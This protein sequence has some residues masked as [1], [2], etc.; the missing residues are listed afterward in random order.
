M[1]KYK[2]IATATFGIEAIVGREVKELGIENV[3]VDNARVLYETDLLGVAKSNLWLRCADRVFLQIGEFKATSF[4]ELFNKTEALPWEKFIPVNGEFPVNGKSV[5]SKLFSVSD[6]Q[7]IVKKAIV[8]R[9]GKSYGVDWFQEDGPK[10]PILVS[11]LKDVVTLSIDT[12]GVGLHKRG[13][14]ATG[15]EA[16]LKETLAAAMLKIARWHSKIPLIDPMCGSGTILIEAAMMGRNIAPGLSRKFVSETWGDDFKEAF[17]AARKEAYDAIE[18]DL[19]LNIKGYD[20]NRRS[21]NIAK[22]NAELAGVDDTITFEVKDAKLLKSEDKY[23]YIISNPPYGERLS[24]KK[25]VESLYKMMGRSYE[26][27]DT[28]S[29]YV[30]TSHE[31]F[32]KN[33]GKKATKNRKLYN[34]RLKC[35]F[36]QYFGPRPPKRTTLSDD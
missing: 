6:C 11:I 7:A 23:G 19:D 29:K 33:Y 8:K 1:E 17:K 32:E 28:W 5:K 30:L 26:G 24:D 13:Y 12:S 9:L 15:N 3:Q 36:Y 22:E 2:V 35:Y 21:V 18:Y 20:I 34:G 14:R 25:A 4:E 16:P 31:E 27:L 10:Y